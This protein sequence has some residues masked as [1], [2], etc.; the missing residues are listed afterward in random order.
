MVVTETTSIKVLVVSFVS[1]YYKIKASSATV[2]NIVKVGDQV[3]SELTVGSE[4]TVGTLVGGQV[5]V[6]KTVGQEVVG[7]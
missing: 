2:G 3:G 5:A 1:K 6:G 7:Q 4:V